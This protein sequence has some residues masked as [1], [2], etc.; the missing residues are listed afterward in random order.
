MRILMVVWDVRLF[1]IGSCLDLG[2][3]VLFIVLFNEDSFLKRFKYK[4]R[5][6]N[7]RWMDLYFPNPF[8]RY[9]S[10]HSKKDPF[11]GIIPDT[12]RTLHWYI[13]QDDM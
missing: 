3:F 8:K 1:L 10:A 11:V 13:A 9:M 4:K 2:E 7:D 12:S 5:Q 6:L